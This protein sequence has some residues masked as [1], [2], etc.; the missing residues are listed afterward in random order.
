VEIVR[1]RW[2]GFNETGCHR[3]RSATTRLTYATGATVEDARVDP[4]EIID[5]HGDGEVVLMLLRASGKAIP[6]SDRCAPGRRSVRAK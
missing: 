4:E 6:E 5:V 3:F 1:R 2:E